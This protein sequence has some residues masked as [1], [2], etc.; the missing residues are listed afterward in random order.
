MLSSA[1]TMKVSMVKY[2]NVIADERKGTKKG[3]KKIGKSKGEG[4]R[5][6]VMGKS[7]TNIKRRFFFLKNRNK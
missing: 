7:A 2:G 5:L 4:V 1:V 3:R 6:K